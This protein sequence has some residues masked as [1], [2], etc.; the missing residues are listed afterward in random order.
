MYALIDS[1]RGRYPVG[2]MARAL[3][4][5][6]RSYF[7]YKQGIYSLRDQKRERLEGLIQ[8]VYAAANRRSKQE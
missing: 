1:N 3:R 5:S 6:P 8:Q 7:N 2:M 4:I